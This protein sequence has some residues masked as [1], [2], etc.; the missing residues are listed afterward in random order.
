MFGTNF[1][2][3][4]HNTVLQDKSHQLFKDTLKLQHKAFKRNTDNFSAQHVKFNFQEKQYIEKQT[5]IRTK[6]QS[7]T[8]FYPVS[9][10][11]TFPRRRNSFGCIHSSRGSLNYRQSIG[12]NSS[13][14][15]HNSCV[16]PCLS[17]S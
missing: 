3:E 4:I 12:V 13:V 1:Q 9:L 14:R 16:S 7:V 10:I 2:V 6:L 5:Q 17:E 15:L 11:K 8:C